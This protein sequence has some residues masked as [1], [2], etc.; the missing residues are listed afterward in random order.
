MII[1]SQVRSTDQMITWKQSR[2]TLKS[3]ND[4]VNKQN[5]ILNRSPS[6]KMDNVR[7]ENDYDYALANELTVRVYQLAHTAHSKVSDRVMFSKLRNS[8]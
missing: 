1:T 5:K 8:Q 6:L 7:D 4:P 3:R 2:N